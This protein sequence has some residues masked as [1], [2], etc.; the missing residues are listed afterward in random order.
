M[1][2]LHGGWD[3]IAFA[4]LFWAVVF[5]GPPLALL[6]GI[7]WV[8]RRRRARRITEAGKLSD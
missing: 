3:T 5:G 6:L 8:L 7:L 1:M 4:L 2:V